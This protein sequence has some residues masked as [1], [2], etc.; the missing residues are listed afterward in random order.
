MGAD[1]NNNLNSTFCQFLTLFG[2]TI[3]PI[4]KGSPEKSNYPAM[5]SVD[6]TTQKKKSSNNVNQIW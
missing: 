1:L 2:K 5:Y 4:K 6:H 3:I